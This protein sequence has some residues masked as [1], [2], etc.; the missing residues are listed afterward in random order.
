MSPSVLNDRLTELREAGVVEHASGG[1]YRLTVHGRELM[2]TLAPLNHWA[3]RWARRE[4]TI[5]TQYVRA[6]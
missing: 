5:A 1:G 6:D 4:G 2:T 3:K